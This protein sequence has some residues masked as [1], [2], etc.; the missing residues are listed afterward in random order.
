MDYQDL[1][2]LTNC[3]TLW[4]RHVLCTLYKMVHD[5][6]NFIFLVTQFYLHTIL[7]YLHPCFTNHMHEQ[8]HS[9]HLLSHQLYPYGTIYPKKPLLLIQ[10]PHLNHWFILVSSSLGCTFCISTLLLCLTLAIGINLLQIKER[11]NANTD[12]QPTLLQSL[13]LKAVVVSSMLQ[14]M[15][16]T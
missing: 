16:L 9:V 12:C 5:L 8:M 10:F 14:A 6:I 3:P 7:L 11:L 2:E 1:L 4:N 13:L 15:Y